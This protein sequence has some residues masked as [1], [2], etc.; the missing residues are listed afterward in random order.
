MLET[1]KDVTLPLRVMVNKE[2][3]KVLFAEADSNSISVLLSFLTLPL[4][5][6]VKILEKHYADNPP[7]F[8]SLT[9]LYKWLENLDDAYFTVTAARPMLLNPPSSS[10]SLF[11]KYKLDIGN[12]LR[13]TE[14][15]ICPGRNCCDRKSICLK[16]GNGYHARCEC[17]KPMIMTL[18]VNDDSKE[19][20]AFTMDTASFVVSDDLEL[21]PNSADFF[22]NL[23]NLVN[24]DSKETGAFTMN[25]ASF[26][27]SDDLQMVPNSAGFFQNLS[28][29][30]IEVGEGAELR[31]LNLGTNEIMDLLKCSLLSKTPLT[32]FILNKGEIISSAEK[33]EPESF[34]NHIAEEET[35]SSKKIILKVVVQKS[36]KKLL[37]A[38]AGDDFIELLFTF[39][40]IPIGEVESLLDSN[41]CLKNLDNLHRSISDV[42]IDKYFITLDT[43][44]RLMKPNIPH[45]FKPKNTILPLTEES[46]PTLYYC[47]E[48]V[49]PFFPQLL[50]SHNHSAFHYSSFAFKSPKGDVNYVKEPTTYMVT[51]DLTVTPLCISNIFAYLNRLSIPLSDVHEVEVPIGFHEGLSILKASL[52]SNSV[53]TDGLIDRITRKQP[54]QEH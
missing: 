19:A 5:R 2:K 21:V 35:S 17:G 20:G 47:Y 24:D 3:T 49:I 9:S 52:T 22:Q 51:D 39:L 37:F 10:D 6:I 33:P 40:I 14:Y 28:N 30:G 25:T 36:T 26:I 50:V 32:D 41:T 42:G 27:V 31:N 23:S 46:V 45:F 53:L 18:V 7:V 44:K 38:Q 29:L 11:R 4:G 48:E 12:Y 34:F 43:K 1:A 15:L 13:S 54:K 8:G 16:Y